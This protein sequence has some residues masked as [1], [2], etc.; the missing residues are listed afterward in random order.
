[1][2]MFPIVPAVLSLFVSSVAFAQAWD[3]YTTRENFFTLN[4]P[5]EPKESSAPYKTAKGT[6]L[7]MKT[8]TAKAP[9]GTLLAGTYAL[10]VIDYSG[11]TGELA[12]AI[13]CCTRLPDPIGA[14]KV[15]FCATRKATRSA[16]R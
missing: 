13:E 14:R 12:T 10:H 11:A 6:N 9:A 4:L 3:I 1:M 2:R 8:W 15:Y 7:T 5:D 16:P